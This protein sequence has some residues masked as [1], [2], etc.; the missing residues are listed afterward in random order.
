MSNLNVQPMVQLMSIKGT[1]C[2]RGRARLWVERDLTKYGFTRHAR[3]SID[4]L[5]TGV[6][7]RL[8]N[9]GK[10]KVAGRPGKAILDI[11]MPLEVREAMR[12]GCE[13]FVVHAQFGLITI[14]PMRSM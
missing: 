11:C 8:D 2:N 13:R 7:V 3:I 4:L 10:R 6:V 5:P 12:D 14:Q 9:N 1:A